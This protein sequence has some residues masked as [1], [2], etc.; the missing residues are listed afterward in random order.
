[1]T[2]ITKVRAI[3]TNTQ[4]KIFLTRD[5]RNNKFMLP[6]GTYEVWETL[7]ECLGREIY[8]ELGVHPE[9][10]NLLSFREYYNYL[11]QYSVDFWYEIKNFQEFYDIQKENCSH[12]HE[13]IEA[14]FYDISLVSSEELMPV[15][16]PELLSEVIQW[17]T[18]KIL[19]FS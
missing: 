16:L 4:G 11:W 14:W 19:H 13:W 18:K 5:C 15:N 10:W 2:L 6:W 7:T 17:W 8:E 9:I 3:I 1:M 12:G